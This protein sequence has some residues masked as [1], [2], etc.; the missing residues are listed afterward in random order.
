M[1]NHSFA[2]GMA[3]GARP[4]FATLILAVTMK[5]GDDSVQHRLINAIR[6][7]SNLTLSCLTAEAIQVIY[8]V[9][10]RL[11][12]EADPA[13]FSVQD[14]S[15]WEVVREASNAS[16]MAHNC[17]QGASEIHAILERFA[18][19]RLPR[20]REESQQLTARLHTAC[21]AMRTITWDK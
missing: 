16:L 6:S 9:T 4:E 18:N 1:N 15:H 14:G 13:C 20:T 11:F 2:L 21:V 5:H 19:E 10:E 12:S 17:P 3:R 7:S 8:K